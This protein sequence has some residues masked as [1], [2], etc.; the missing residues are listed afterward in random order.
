MRD[1]LT[2]KSCHRRCWALEF[3]KMRCYSARGRERCSFSYNAITVARGNAQPV[4]GQRH[5]TPQSGKMFM[6]ALEV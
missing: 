6:E 5:A 2:K 3:F 4:R 1:L